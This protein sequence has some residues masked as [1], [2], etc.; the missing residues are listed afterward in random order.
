MLRHVIPDQN[1]PFTKV[2]IAGYERTLG[3]PV[4]FIMDSDKVLYEV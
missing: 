3:V 2:V 1:F 4:K